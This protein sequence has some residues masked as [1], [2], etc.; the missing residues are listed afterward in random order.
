MNES[1]FTK[2][3]LACRD[4][5]KPVEGHGRYCNPVLDRLLLTLVVAAWLALVALMITLVLR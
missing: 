3:Q 5:G 2:P 1:P 4:C